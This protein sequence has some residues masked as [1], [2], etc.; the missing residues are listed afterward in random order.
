[1][2]TTPESGE[3][4]PPAWVRRRTA[5][6]ARRAPG[7]EV[8]V[9][10]RVRGEVRGRL[11]EGGAVG[12]LRSTGAIFGS[13]SGLGDPATGAGNAVGAYR[14]LTGA[15]GTAAL[16]EGPATLS[17][18]RTYRRRRAVAVRDSASEAGNT[19]P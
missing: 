7:A 9:P 10:V 4:G 12:P 11:L 13:P 18:W 16:V 5:R 19:G 2:T 15:G 1:V 14:P 6:G 8:G 17:G 3:E